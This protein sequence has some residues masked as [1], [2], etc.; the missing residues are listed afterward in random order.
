MRVVVL[1]NAEEALAHGS[2]QD[3]LA[4]VSVQSCARAVA[5]ALATLGHEARL[6]PAP[7]QPA[8]L[9]AALQ[10][11]HPDVVFNLVESYR[12]DAALEPAV[13]ALLELTG[14]PFTGNRSLACALSLR[15]PLAKAL[16]A[17]GGVPVAD[18]VVFERGDPRD[19]ALLAALAAR[20]PFPWI[21]KPAREDASHGITAASVVDDVAAARA[22]AR[23]VVETYRQPALVERF[24]A[25]RELNVALVGTADA[26]QV[27]PVAEIDFA[28]F[29]S[30]RPRLVTF[31]SKW[32]EGSPD[33]NGT[34][35][36]DAVLAPAVAAR[37]QG[38][39]LAA[40]HALSLTG[41]GRID[42]RLDGSDAPIVL[43]ANPNPDL[44]PDAGFARAWGRTGATYE[45]L[46]ARL[47]ALAR[48]GPVA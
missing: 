39:A 17:A 44:S 27:L 31:E 34:N 10:R 25:G 13:A 4:V 46:V 7:D 37:V 14:L 22:R 5:A 16:L 41:Y 1:H 12:G 20:A 35:V 24:V 32:V 11:A 40:W 29:P 8:D 48:P 2:A 42:L 3:A 23:Y 6:Q 43:E 18:G 33:W 30:G 47:L 45:Q 38:A 19:D 36:V 9:L 26:P 21:V 28:K 15:K